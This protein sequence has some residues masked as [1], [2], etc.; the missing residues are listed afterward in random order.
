M[1]RFELFV[2]DG[3]DAREQA[4]ARHGEPDARLAVLEDQQRGEHPGERVPGQLVTLA[5]A[6]ATTTF[7]FTVRLALLVAA[8]LHAPLT[9]TL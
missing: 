5:G 2:H 7:S 1:R 8:L 9:A 6:L 4:V 3:K